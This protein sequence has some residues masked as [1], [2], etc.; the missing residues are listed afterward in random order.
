MEFTIKEKIFDILERIYTF[1]PQFIMC[2]VYIW[3]VE[4][5]IKIITEIKKIIPD[6]IIILGGPE[7]GNNAKKL[8]TFHSEI[9]YIVRGEGEETSVNLIDSLLYNREI[10]DNVFYRDKSGVVCKKS[11]RFMDF[12]EVI[13]PYEKESIKT[14]NNKI[15]YYESSRGCPYNC[16]YCISSL[17]NRVRFRSLD[18]VFSELDFFLENNIPLVKFVDRTFNIKKERYRSIWKY[19]L[20][21]HNGATLFHFEIKAELLDDE[22]IELLKNV[23][24]GIFQ[25]E[26]GIQ[27]VI[28]K[29]LSLVNR[30]TDNN[31]QYEMIS[32]IPETIHTHLDLIAGLPGE[33]MNEIARSF[34]YTIALRPDMLQFGFLKI[35][36]NTEMHSIAGRLNYKWLSSPPYE[37]V[38]SDM[39]NFD[40]FVFLKHFEQVL[41]IYY[42]Y[43]NFRATI[44][45]F[46]TLYK[47]F[48]FFTDL[49]VYLIDNKIM[50]ND[51]KIIGY[52]TY[53]YNYSSI[54]LD[55]DIKEF[56][57]FDFLKHS[58]IRKYPDWFI[59]RYDKKRHEKAVKQHMSDISYRTGFINSNFQHFM[60][61][62]LT[63]KDEETDI[64][65]IY[66]DRKCVEVYAV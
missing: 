62:P 27:S 13:F 28:D 61:N 50:E 53:L 26:I 44:D 4:F 30:K 15:V 64:L 16:A 54:K 46:L 31:K 58:N 1:K 11:L 52:F 12:D 9:D 55:C 25:F 5:T 41:D 17:D 24:R 8:L 3:N 49:T 34:D 63:G 32:K 42:N 23:K 35:L 21:H 19:I 10:P 56:L 51:H 36:S 47:P 22:D 38:K 14:L 33:G 45:Y 18:K 43:K 40:D 39:L 48:E 20:D 65:F 7:A 57:M 37:V 29:T 6:V 2:S 66:R 59:N 60:L